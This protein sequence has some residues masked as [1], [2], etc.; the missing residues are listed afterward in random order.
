[1]LYKAGV[2]TC[3][4]KHEMSRADDTIDEAFIEV[5]GS[6]AVCT[7]TTEYYPSRLPTSKHYLG[8]AKDFR[9][10]HLT[11]NTRDDVRLAV[12]RCLRDKYGANQYDVVF[13]ANDT[14]LH[15]EF[16]PKQ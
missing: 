6:E 8:V 7:S 1:M 4:V 14:I 11:L 10:R 2:C 16:D 12:K 9:L 5:T 13:S 3:N 15:V